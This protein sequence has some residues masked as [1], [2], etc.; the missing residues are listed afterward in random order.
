MNEKFETIE[1]EIIFN[2]LLKNLPADSHNNKFNYEGNSHKNTHYLGEIYPFLKV[3]EENKNNNAHR[4]LHSHRKLIGSSIVFAKKVVRKLLKWYI[5]PI[6]LQQTSFNNAAT[7]AIGKISKLIEEIIGKLDASNSK[8]E[9]YDE[10]IQQL[11]NQ[12][13]ELS[14]KVL[15]TEQ[16]YMA[17]FDQLQTQNNELVENMFRIQEK[18]NKLIGQVDLDTL[19]CEQT[20]NFFDKKTY[21]QSGEDSILAYILHVLGIPFEAISYIDLG[22]NHAKEMSNTFYFYS[23]GAKGVL[24]EANPDLIPELKFYRDRDLIL[25]NVVD[26]EDDKE[27]DFYILSGDGL[28]TPDYESAKNFCEINPSIEIVN[29]KVLKTITYNTIVEQFLGQSPTILSID[30]E[31]KDLEI[32]KSMNLEEYRPLLIVTEMIIYDTKLNYHTKNKDITSYL[33]SMDYDEYAFTGINSIF[34]DRR[35]L[36]ERDGFKE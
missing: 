11:Q 20:Y 36:E 15:Q 26:I 32:L 29:K 7:S 9:D 22:A 23:F 16:K 19:T 27:V 1:H 34:I 35:F 18:H 10:K 8:C 30:I 13:N 4:Y 3:M 14:K 31:G 24:V 33:D 5:N 21:G 28:S 17:Q 2:K 25:N 12:Y 6:T